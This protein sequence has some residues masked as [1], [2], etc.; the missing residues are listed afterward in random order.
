MTLRSIVVSL[1]SLL[2]KKQ[3]CVLLSSYL[4]HIFSSPVLYFCLR[5]CSRK[6]SKVS[7][8]TGGPKTGSSD[9][10]SFIMFRL[11]LMTRLTFLKHR[12]NSV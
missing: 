11:F 3:F 10:F 1:Y 12:R 9:S 2:I 6:E 8:E 7:A 4:V 5:I